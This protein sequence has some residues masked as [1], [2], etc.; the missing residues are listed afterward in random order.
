MRKLVS[1]RKIDSLSPIEGADKIELA[2]TGGWQCVVGKGSFQSGE[3]AVFFEIDS[4][5]PANDERYSFL[6]ERCLRKWLNHGKLVCEVIRIKTCK[7][8]GQISQ[9]LFMPLTTFPELKEQ[10]LLEGTDLTEIL[11]VKH[12][13]DLAEE[14]GRITGAARVAGNAKGSFPAFIPKTDEERLQNLSEYF[15]QMKNVEFECTEKFD[16]SSM[17]V[18]FSKQNRNDCPF[19]VCSRNIDLKLEDDSNA[20][21]AMAN[22][23]DLQKKLQEL[24]R[25]I[26]IQGELV[27]P[28]LNGN[29][30]LYEFPE[31]RVF[32]IF[33]IEKKQW[34]CPE[35][36][37]G[38][39]YDLDLL[40]V[41][42]IR[43]KW[44]VFNE[45]TTM[46]DFLEFVKGKTNR[47]HE[48]EG[49]V[50]KSMDGFVSFKVINN[51]YLLKQKD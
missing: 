15:E 30:D 12:Y 1:I 39:C 47:G 14:M 42:V 41:K 35:E 3:L 4:A 26:A 21:V 40:H 32:R 23:L 10:K 2:H 25:E 28:G 11:H 19:G 8:K 27:G 48:R 20:F 16:G 5:L 50:W 7:F 24:N 51:D 18:Y 31:F 46:N 45:L 22:K 49:M 29:R 36:R 44:K 13:D 17:T 33:D 6:K 38:L 37:Y 43:H 34:V 9:G